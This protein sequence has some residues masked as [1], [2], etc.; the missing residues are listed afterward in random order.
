[1]IS[2]PLTKIVAVDDDVEVTERQ[3]LGARVWI[4]VEKAKLRRRW[5][6]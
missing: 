3:R 5:R 1:M 4:L 2:A 6:G